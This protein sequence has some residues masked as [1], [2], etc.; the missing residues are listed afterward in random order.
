MRKNLI[1]NTALFF[2]MGFLTLVYYRF[3]VSSSAFTSVYISTSDM[4]RFFN[5]FALGEKTSLSV[6]SIKNIM[7]TFLLLLTKDSFFSFV[8]TSFIL[9]L[10]SVFLVYKISNLYKDNNWYGL[11]AVLIFTTI[12]EMFLRVYAVNVHISETMLLL[13]VVWFYGKSENFTFKKYSLCYLIF[14]L[15]AFFERESI[16]IYLGLILFLSSYICLKRK[17][18]I[19]CT[20][21]AVI[22]FIIAAAIFSSKHSSYIFERLSHWLVYF[23]TLEAGVVLQIPYLT[24]CEIFF[25]L[26]QGFSSFYLLV[27]L[28]ALL[29]RLF[30]SSKAKVSFFLFIESFISMVFGLYLFTVIP[31]HKI[32]FREM[33]DT[34]GAVLDDILPVF[35]FL[36]IFLANFF[37]I[38]QRLRKY[39]IASAVV[40][41][42]VF[43]VNLF[44]YSLSE[45]KQQESEILQDKTRY[46]Y[47]HYDISGQVESSIN[48]NGFFFLLKKNNIPAEGLSY[49]ISI[50]Y[51]SVMDIFEDM[52]SFVEDVFC[53]QGLKSAYVNKEQAKELIRLTEIPLEDVFSFFVCYSQNDFAYIISSAKVKKISSWQIIIN[54]ESF[55]L[56]FYAVV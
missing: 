32:I 18:Y 3:C 55:D 26:R 16:V 47:L 46:E 11:L 5:L 43:P 41:F 56:L 19:S 21:N 23:K 39:I 31:K 35:A 17:K 24:V 25:Q 48:H 54:D 2:Y 22:A 40:I 38:C 4:E 33:F 20:Y 30:Y 8:W 42:F 52:F 49:S 9:Y 10:V 27:L 7:Y 12:P 6:I 13:A 45:F 53:L 14:A 29:C 15:A 34:Q 37:F 44:D 50:P 51:L 36:A 28:L 1:A